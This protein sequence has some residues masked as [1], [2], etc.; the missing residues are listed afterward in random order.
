MFYNNN[1]VHQ[2][3]PAVFPAIPVPAALWAGLMLV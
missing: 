2:T 1:I 3:L